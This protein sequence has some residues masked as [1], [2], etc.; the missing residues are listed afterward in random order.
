MSFGWHISTLRKQREII[1]HSAP[2]LSGKCQN[3]GNGASFTLIVARLPDTKALCGSAL[4]RRSRSSH[5]LDL[6][7]VR[8]KSRRKLQR[9]IATNAS[10]CVHDVVLHTCGSYFAFKPSRWPFDAS[11][12]CVRLFLRFSA[13]LLRTPKDM[14][15]LGDKLRGQTSG[16][17]FACYDHEIVCAHRSRAP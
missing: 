10:Y 13:D 7:N 2:Y 12:F 6:Q 14:V 8:K 15:N 4:C 3:C 1:C 9:S 11:N 5:H 16:S 17:G